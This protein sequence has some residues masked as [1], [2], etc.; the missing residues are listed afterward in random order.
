MALFWF[1]DITPNYF[2][3]FASFRL[4]LT[5]QGKHPPTH[6]RQLMAISPFVDA[7]ETQP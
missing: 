1:H 2:G 7:S 5:G 4:S 6:G 3:F